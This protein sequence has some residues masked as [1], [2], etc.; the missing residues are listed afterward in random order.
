MRQERHNAG[1]TILEII[2]AFAIITTILMLTAPFIFSFFRQNTL[3]AERNILLGL[4]KQA[5]TLSM[6]NEQ[7]SS[8]GV[9]IGSSQFT[10]FKGNTYASRDISFDY[11]VARQSGTTISGPTEIEFNRL[12]GRTASTS[13]EIQLAQ[14]KTKIRINSEGRFTW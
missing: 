11:A 10:L 9:H 5:R 14:N 2:I 1:F 8:Y 4:L 3:R 13:F 12:S 7:L 6:T